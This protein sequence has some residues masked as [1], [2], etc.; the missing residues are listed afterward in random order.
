[1]TWVL[2]LFVVNT[3]A[4]ALTSV[5]GFASEAQCRA[6]GERAVEAFNTGGFTARERYVCVAHG[7]AKKETP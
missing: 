5:P 1:M 6:A 3:E 4:R 2:I 7:S